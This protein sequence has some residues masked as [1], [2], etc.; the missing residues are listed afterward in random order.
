[1]NRIVPLSVGDVLTM[2][3]PH[4]CKS[5]ELEVRR[6]GS[7][8]RVVCRGCARDMTLAREKLEKNIRRING[9]PVCDILRT[10]TASDHQN[11]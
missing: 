5:C 2:K 6:V 3:K 9:V 1:M 4:P 8:V 10:G 11:D 7:D